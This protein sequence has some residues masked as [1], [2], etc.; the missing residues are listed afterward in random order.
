MDRK[1]RGRSPEE[2][3]VESRFGRTHSAL[4]LLSRNVEALVQSAFDPPVVPIQPEHLFGIKLFPGEAGQEVF[5]FNLLLPLGPP[6]YES[7][8]LCGLCRMG[9]PGL[10]G[11]DIKTQEAAGLGTTPVDLIALRQIVRTLR[12]KKRHAGC[13]VAFATRMQ[14][15]ADCL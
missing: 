6:V 13:C 4:V 14:V 10:F 5:A 15:Q 11:G 9:E 1:T 2:A 7:G 12:G 3:E 8:H